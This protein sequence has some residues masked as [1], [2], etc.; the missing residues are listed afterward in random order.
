VARVRRPGD[1]KVIRFGTAS[2]TLV[3][4]RPSRP[5]SEPARALIFGHQQDSPRERLSLHLSSCASDVADL[6]RPSVP[7]KAPPPRDHRRTRVAVDVPWSGRPTA[8]SHLR[9]F[10]QASAPWTGSGVLRGRPLLPR[11]DR[12]SSASAHRRYPWADRLT[13]SW[14]LSQSRRGGYPRDGS[15]PR[16]SHRR[17]SSGLGNAAIRMLLRTA[18]PAPSVKVSADA[19]PLKSSPPISPADPRPH[20][21]HPQRLQPH[22]LRP[23]EKCASG[24]LPTRDRC[25]G[26]H[27]M[28]APAT[29]GPSV[30]GRGSPSMSVVGS[31]DCQLAAAS[32][33]T[34]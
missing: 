34:G 1:R 32:I 18:T 16:H 19:T 33:S 29:S 10:A 9:R 12:P 27:G 28:S 4:S 6:L 7:A 3:V 2:R 15:R 5:P 24:W 21:A 11:P 17:T 31:P 20:T 26:S 8:N 25:R 30:V 13:A 22:Q 23:A 14:Q